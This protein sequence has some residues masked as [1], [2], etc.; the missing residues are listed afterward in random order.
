MP[1]LQYPFTA[2]LS[3]PSVQAIQS[4]IQQNILRQRQKA[5]AKAESERLK[6]QSTRRIGDAISSGVGQMANAFAQ[7]SLTEQQREHQIDLMQNRSDI[8]NFG[9]ATKD[10]DNMADATR[11]EFEEATQQSI[12]PTRF[13]A[14]YRQQIVQQREQ[15][16]QQRKLQSQA[17]QQQQKLA[18]EEENEALHLDPQRTYTLQEQEAHGLAKSKYDS[19]MAEKART[20]IGDSTISSQEQSVEEKSLRGDVHRTVKSGVRKPKFE[21]AQHLDKYTKTVPG[22]GTFV[23]NP[24][25][26]AIKFHQERKSKGDD[27]PLTS[28]DAYDKAYDDLDNSTPEQVREHATILLQEDKERRQRRAGFKKQAMGEQRAQNLRNTQFSNVP[29]APPR[30]NLGRILQGAGVIPS[31]TPAGG[32]P[33]PQQPARPPAAAGQPQQPQQR[34]KPPHPALAKI[35]PQ[36][37]NQKAVKIIQKA[38]GTGDPIVIE[39]LKRSGMNR[40]EIKKLFRVGQVYVSGGDAAVWD[41]KK[42]IPLENPT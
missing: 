22:L 41:G 37:I 4:L 30:G 36:N 1:Q 10:L 35:A 6:T 9:V 8:K 31:G 20:G 3:P 2:G 24:K 19:F 34:Q 21:V 25:D 13:R 40:S 27:Q 12:D 23:T 14:E 26:G 28:D 42:F 18:I 5:Q 11:V 7:R 16:K 32:A 39:D 38:G 33:M 15:E 29:A 17:Q